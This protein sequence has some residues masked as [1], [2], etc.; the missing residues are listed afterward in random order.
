MFHISM[1]LCLCVYDI[2]MY[3]CVYMYICMYID[4]YTK[5][6]AYMYA[7]IQWICMYVEFLSDPLSRVLA[8]SFCAN[9]LIT[10]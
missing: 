1:L 5:L 6:H 7:D 3:I 2:Y 9:I 10:C 8:V 4:T